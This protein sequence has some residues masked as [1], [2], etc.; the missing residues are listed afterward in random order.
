M[1]APPLT[2]LREP[3]RVL[4]QADS[5]VGQGVGVLVREE[6]AGRSPV[7]DLREG[8]QV[9]GEDRGS[10][11]HGLDQ[12]DA[13]ALAA[14]VG[15]DIQVDAAQEARLVLVADHAEELDAGA[16]LSREGLHRLLLVAAPGDQQ[17]GLRAR[18]EDL[19]QGLHE[20]RQP[21]AGL[22][23]APDEADRVAL[24][25]GL[26]LG[27]GEEVDVDAVRDHHRVPAE[28]LHQRAPGV[29]AHRD[30]RADL[31][32]G[33]LEDRVR[34]DHGPGARVGRVERGDDRA[35]RRPAGQQAQRGRRR[36]VDVDHVERAVVQPPA[37]PGRREEA[38]VQPGHRAVVRH[39][40]RAPG[41]D[42]VRRQRGVVVRRGEDGH[43][44]A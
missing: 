36:L 25:L 40:N 17:P 18:G 16:Q 32:Q 7:Q 37:H 4:Q 28:V 8:V 19:R 20:H 10:G 39:R 11:G 3:R 38:E 41:R 27:L 12:D 33:G 43:L 34:G 23:D 15:R 35:L 31:L 42:D 9:G 6:F 29:L 22:V 14:G 13:E 2:Q 44:V 24:P 5:G 21:L 30:P 1:R 26:G